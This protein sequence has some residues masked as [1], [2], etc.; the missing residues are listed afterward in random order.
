MTLFD[1]PTAQLD[2]F[3]MQEL[4]QLERACAA[5]Y[6]VYD[7]AQV[8]RRL[9]EFTNATLSNL[10]LD[11]G[12][13]SL[14]LDESANE[15]RQMIV[16][17]VDQILRTMTGIMAP[18]TPFLCE[19]IFHF[20]NGASSDPVEGVKG[21]ESVFING[22]PS[23]DETWNDKKTVEECKQLLKLR[24]ASL[25]MIE[26]ARQASHIKTSF[27]VEI[28]LIIKDRQH[29]IASAVDHYRKSDDRCGKPPLQFV[30]NKAD[31]LLFCSSTR[32]LGSELTELFNVARVNVVEQGQAESVS[33]QV[34]SSRE[35]EDGVTIRVCRSPRHRCPRCRALRKDS[36]SDRLCRRCQSVV[37][38]LS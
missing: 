24:D 6:E 33:K 35:D 19:E 32:S 22:W 30:G 5:A 16:A 7:F 25:V 27:E 21:A 17:V 34:F 10:Y 3:V 36:E 31:R 23:V 26:E 11:V 28:D 14:Y 29:A 15:R 2:R 1:Y 9:T 20:R 38:A 13:D 37:D 12:K 4:Y 8:V 18:I